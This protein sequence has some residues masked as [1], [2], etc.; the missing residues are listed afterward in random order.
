MTRPGPLTSRRNLLRGAAAGGAGLLAGGVALTS[1]S[2]AGAAATP[3][4]P[5]DVVEPVPFYGVHQAGIATPAQDRLEF[6]AFDVTTDDVGALQAMLGKWAA[7]AAR[8][9]SGELIGA[10]EIHPERPPMD[11]GE[12]LGL[13]PAQL[14][15]TVGFGPSFFDERFG[16]ADRRPAL[17]TDLPTFR[18]D[19]IDPARSGGDICVQACSND[20]QVA[21]HAVRNFAR[22][23]RGVVVMRWSQLGFGRTSSTSVTQNT[24]RN[25]MG[26][27]DGTNNVKAENSADMSDFVWVGDDADQA[28]MV[29]GTYLVARRIRMLIES[30]DNTSLNE[31]ERVIGR[32]RATGAPLGGEEEFDP[33]DLELPDDAGGMVIDEAAHIR[34]ASPHSHGGAKMLRRGYSFTDGMDA[35]TGRLDAGLFFICFVRDPERQFV[36]VQR[37]LGENDLLNEYINH[38]GT[39]LFAVPPGLIEVGD[40]YGKSLWAS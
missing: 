10:A 24:P 29:G 1:A 18:N 39:G 15:I 2:H 35:R 32:A 28:W 30:W 40:W 12:A 23:G 8:M 22:I 33:V 20:P 34:L 7:A 3:I 9:A 5:A 26:F 38:T 31:Q 16:L 21:F 13:D 14:T 27:K 36:P 25:L 37:A 4:S 19:V 11:T 6:A 17:L